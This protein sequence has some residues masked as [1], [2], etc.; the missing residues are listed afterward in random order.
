MTICQLRKQ[1][2]YIDFYFFEDGYE[3]QKAPFFHA[4]IKSFEVKVDSIFIYM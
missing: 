4:T 3:M 1:F 2:P